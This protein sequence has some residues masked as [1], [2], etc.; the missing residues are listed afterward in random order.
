MFEK[1]LD[2]T[3]CFFTRRKRPKV[4]AFA[5]D[6]FDGVLVDA[7]CA[8]DAGRTKVAKSRSRAPAVNLCA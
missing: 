1:H 7:E 4:E 8:H 2:V 5:P 6:V 3:A